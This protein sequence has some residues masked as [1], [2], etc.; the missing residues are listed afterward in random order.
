[1]GSKYVSDKDSKYDVNFKLTKIFIPIK[2]FYC[3]KDKRTL[4]LFYLPL[5]SSV[6]GSKFLTQLQR[7]KI[8]QKNFFSA[9]AR[10]NVTVNFYDNDYAM[11]IV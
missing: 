5:F 3:Q 6:G 4:I 7:K 1:M 11:H 8:A 10:I 2:T 9:I